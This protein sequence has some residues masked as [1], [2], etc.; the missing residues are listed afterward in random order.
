MKFRIK[1]LVRRPQQP[2]ARRNKILQW[3]LTHFYIF[4]IISLASIPAA[5][6][7]T[8]QSKFC[9]ASCHIMKPN[10]ETY[11]QDKHFEKNILCVDCHYA[12]GEKI[13]PKAKF[14]GMAQLF[15]YLSLNEMEVRKRPV[16][17]DLSCTAPSCHPKESFYEKKIDYIKSYATNYK[18]EL[19]PFVHKTHFEDLIEGH[20]LHCSTCHM[21]AARDKHMDVPM[22]ICFICHF[23]NAPENDGRAECIVCHTVKSGEMEPRATG[24]VTSSELKKLIAHQF[25][26]KSKV[27]CSSCH[28]GII[29]VNSKIKLD[30]CL[31]CH[32]DASEEMLAKIADKKQI[33]E[34]HVAKQSARCTQCHEAVTHKMIY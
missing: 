27:V 34:A 31:E 7:Y 16:I 32:H 25:L 6:M 23:R 1:R 2:S 20:N 5:E 26:E 4:V 11:K 12:P 24:A 33:H 28:L 19:K 14:K 3:A 29:R 30:Y 21:H 22:V 8:S 15:S 18:G 10:W 13:T 17:S 9:G